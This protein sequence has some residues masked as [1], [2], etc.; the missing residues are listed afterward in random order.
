[1]FLSSPGLWM[2]KQA[3]L[4]LLAVSD[5]GTRRSVQDIVQKLQRTS[6]PKSHSQTHS[7]FTIYLQRDLKFALSYPDVRSP[8]VRRRL[9]RRVPSPGSYGNQ[10]TWEFCQAHGTH[11]PFSTSLTA[12]GLEPHWE[13]VGSFLTRGTLVLCTFLILLSLW[14]QQLWHQH[15]TSL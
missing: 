15:A 12:A 8:D 13:V 3:L 6:S 10:V 14:W 1:M 11:V 9:K 2:S 7:N 4:S 5:Q